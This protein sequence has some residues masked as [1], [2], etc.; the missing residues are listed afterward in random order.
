MLLHFDPPTQSIIS[1][2][3]FNQYKL[4][5]WIYKKCDPLSENLLFYQNSD[6]PYNC[7]KTY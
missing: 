5:D 3:N 6:L 4:C 2:I 7:I 1:F